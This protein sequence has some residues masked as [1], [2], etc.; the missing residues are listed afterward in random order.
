MCLFY[1][2]TYEKELS[3]DSMSNIRAY[4]WMGGAITA[5]SPKESKLK[6]DIGV[7]CVLYNLPKF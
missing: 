3:T 1:K 7:V 4:I 5:W 2:M 6:T